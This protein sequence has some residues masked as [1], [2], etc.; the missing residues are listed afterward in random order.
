VYFILGICG[1]LKLVSSVI[2]TKNM[3]TCSQFSY[4]LAKPNG[5]AVC[6]VETS[7]KSVYKKN[8]INIENTNSFMLIILRHVWVN[9]LFIYF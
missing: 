1:N 6:F 4:G 2:H 5:I 9:G 7:C 3:G 8:V